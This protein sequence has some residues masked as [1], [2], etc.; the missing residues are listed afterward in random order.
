M[1]SEGFDA[2]S[3]GLR[4]TLCALGNGRFVTRGAACDSRAD[5]VHYPGCYLTGGYDRL[6]TVVN[7]REIENEDGPL[8]TGEEKSRK[9]DL[10]WALKRILRRRRDRDRTFSDRKPKHHYP[11]VTP[12]NAPTAAVAAIARAPQNATLAAPRTK[13]APPADAPSPPRIARPMSVDAATRRAISVSG[14]SGAT[15]SGTTAPAAKVSA[16]TSAAW[17]GRAVTVSDMPSSSRAWAPR[18]SFAVNCTATRRARRSSRPR[19]T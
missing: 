12:N 6:T 7:G 3:E 5:E 8:L 13:P 15:I 1:T 2:A 17:T 11:A 9:A 16:E 10:T 4:E 14:T 18:A 19:A